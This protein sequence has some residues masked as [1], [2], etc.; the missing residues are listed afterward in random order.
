[1]KVMKRDNWPELMDSAKQSVLILAP[2]IDDALIKE[3]FGFL[4][5]VDVCIV[6]PRK[7]LREKGDRGDRYALRGVLDTNFDAEIRVTDEDI[8]ACLVVDGKDFY[9]SETYAD[10]LEGRASDNESGIEYARAIWDAS[11]PWA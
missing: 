4:P 9:Y 5:P 10:R 11:R 1:M 7:T 6:F 3:L 8:A 2:W